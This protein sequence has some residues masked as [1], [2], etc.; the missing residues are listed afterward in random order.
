MPLFE[1]TVN[2]LT[3]LYNHTSLFLAKL[4]I[5]HNFVKLEYEKFD[6]NKVLS[7]PFVFL[8]L[9]LVKASN[10]ITTLHEKKSS[11]VFCPTCSQFPLL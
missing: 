9:V 10:Y 5:I 4:T 6:L 1:L 11:R 3:I 8:F 7:F 2:G